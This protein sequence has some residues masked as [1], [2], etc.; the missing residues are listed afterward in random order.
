MYEIA[1]TLHFCNLMKCLKKFIE[2]IVMIFFLNCDKQ[3]ITILLH[4]KHY[5][6]IFAIYCYLSAVMSYKIKYIY[7]DSNRYKMHL[8]WH[9]LN[10]YK[11][12][13]FV[14]VSFWKFYIDPFLV[15]VSLF[16]KI[17]NHSVNLLKTN[18]ILI[19]FRLFNMEIK[20]TCLHFYSL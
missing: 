15:N 19:C 20:I 14:K 10:F 1:N 16:L 3:I 18:L 6:F 7:T 13:I 9:I 8:H 2:F 5:W 11:M 12:K 4:F 17:F